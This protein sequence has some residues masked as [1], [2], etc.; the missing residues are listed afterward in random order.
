VANPS[1]RLLLIAYH[2]AGHAVFVLRYRRR[3]KQVSI[4]PNEHSRGRVIANSGIGSIEGYI[5]P[6]RQRI[7]EEWVK[8]LLAGHIAQHLHAPNSKYIYD[9]RVDRAHADELLGQISDSN[10]EATARFNLLR[11]QTIQIVKRPSVWAQITAVAEALLR[12]PTLS[13]DEVRDI[14]Q[15]A[16]GLKMAELTKA[17]KA[18]KQAAAK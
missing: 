18:H 8:I 4:D 16:G 2:E 17:L 10:E 12:Q 13:G 6:R 3:L 15:R 1:H 11:I 5:T 9:G 7:I 14:C